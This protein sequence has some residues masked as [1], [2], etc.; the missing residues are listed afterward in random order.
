M[1]F[2]GQNLESI[3]E[4]MGHSKGSKITEKHY[5][6]P[7]ILKLSHAQKEAEKQEALFNVM[8]GK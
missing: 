1:K 6:D 7:R 3:Q 2:A 4:V 8:I 5:I